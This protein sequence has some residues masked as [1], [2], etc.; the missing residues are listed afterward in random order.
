MFE[1]RDLALLQD[2]NRNK[3]K[4]TLKKLSSNITAVLADD[5]DGD[6]ESDLLQAVS[7]NL[8]DS[9]EINRE[10]SCKIILEILN[11]RQEL[12]SD[13][14]ACLIPALSVRL[15]S[16]E[17]Y[18][19]CEEIR[20]AQLTILQRL[21]TNCQ[22]VEE[23]RVLTGWMTEIV[24]ILVKTGEDKYHE[25]RKIAFLVMREFIVRTKR[26]VHLMAEPMLKPLIKSITH[27]HSKVRVSAIETLGLVVMHGGKT[28]L[29]DK[30]HTHL[31][32]RLFDP[33]AAV[34][35]QIV[36]TATL[37]LKDYQ[38]RYSFWSQLTP[39]IFTCFDDEDPLVS[40]FK[41]EL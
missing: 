17:V 30:L 7:K 9:S 13:Y 28:C 10:L 40:K 25:G 12:P 15:A 24:K 41:L 31:A 36:R 37:W 5:E 19:E 11:S 2:E 33:H 14:Y 38:D 35:Q 1:A 29:P 20:H 22:R 23:E 8:L 3:R 34:R 18:E 32:Q 26:T 16:E 6:L 21:V 27:Q 4:L 39:L